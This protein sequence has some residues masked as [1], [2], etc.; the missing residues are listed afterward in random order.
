MTATDLKKMVEDNLSVD[1]GEM[2]MTLAE[3]FIQEGIQK[4]IQ[5]GIQQ[6]IRQGLTE[7]IE[8]GLQLRFGAEG[9]RLMP[10]I[11]KIEDVP[12]LRS[13]K[14]A[15]RSM[16]NIDEIKMVIK[17]LRDEAMSEKEKQ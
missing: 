3:K 13:V 5:Q 9:Y 8:M 15:V 11:Y 6:G 14:D 16:K 12:A 4:G 17:G 7:A 10:K 2:I 1:Q